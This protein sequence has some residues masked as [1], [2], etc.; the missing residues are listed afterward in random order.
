MRVSNAATYPLVAPHLAEEIAVTH[1]RVPRGLDQRGGGG[2]E[3]VLLAAATLEALRVGPMALAPAPTR[4]GTAAWR[5]VRPAAT[6]LPIAGLALAAAVVL[7]APADEGPFLVAAALLAAA[8]GLSATSVGIHG[9]LL[10]PGLFL[11][12]VEPR[13]AAPVSL[14]L[15]VLSIP[16]GAAS[17]AAVGHVQRSITGP[18]TMGGVVGS[19][20]SALLASSIPADLVTRAVAFV[21]ILVGVIVLATL[22]AGYAA[23]YVDHEEIHPAR[24]GGVGA[25][26]G[27]ASGIPGVGW[28]PV[29][30]TLLIVSRIDPRHAIG[31]SLVGRAVMA[32]AAVATYAIGA[33]TLGGFALAPALEGRP[34]RR[35]DRGAG[36]GAH[37]GQRPP[38]S[39][40]SR[41][42]LPVDRLR[43]VHPGGRRRGGSPC[44]P[45]VVGDAGE[46]GVRAPRVPRR[47]PGGGEP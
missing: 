29:G 13:V 5:R 34:A 40:A 19:V 7:V 3:R 12:G 31:S 28:G 24:I 17:H 23:G 44:G 2:P 45:L 15:Q 36:L 47:A 21:V 8:A 9:G 30:V 37:P 27:L 25:V 20:N 46:P 26:A 41:P 11:L 35:L 14:L 42:R 18:L 10:V 1:P 4:R 39:R 6:V 43:A 32:V 16:V 33:A 22:R 38:I